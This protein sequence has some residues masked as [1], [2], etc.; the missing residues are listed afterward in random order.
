VFLKA[1]AEL[2]S[3]LRAFLLL[4]YTLIA[5]TAYLILVEDG[6]AVPPVWVCAAIAMALVSNVLA[7]QLPEKILDSRYFATGMI[8]ADTTWITAALVSSGRFDVDFFFLYFFVLLLAAMGE[9]LGL[10]AVAAV[11]VCLAY[12][13]VLSSS[14]QAWSMWN[15]PSIIRL[16]FLFTAAAFYGYMIDRTRRVERQA[17]V[18]KEQAQLRGEALA[19]VARQVRKPLGALLSWTNLLLDTPLSRRQREYADRARRHGKELLAIVDGVLDVAVLEAGEVHLDLVAFELPAVVEEVCEAFGAQAREQGLAFTFEVDGRIPILLHGA[20]DRIRRV[21]SNVIDNAIKFTDRG[22][23]TVS[24]RLVDRTAGEV[25]V[26]FEVT[27]SGR[28]IAP[29]HQGTIFAPLGEESAAEAPVGRTLGL[30]IAS[31]LVAAMGGVISVTSTLGK[32]S[33]FS[34]TIRL[35]EVAASEPQAEHPAEAELAS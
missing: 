16:P 14:G 18:A 34:L 10:I 31:Q 11:A 22:G 20:P 32:G 21:L 1:G 29:E 3:R 35:A 12:V 8:L 15:S 26:G 19:A 27:D 28:G 13:Y 4:R 6:F 17:A 23:V 5:A 33:T 30:A 25:I 24:A 9:S 7:S 2:L